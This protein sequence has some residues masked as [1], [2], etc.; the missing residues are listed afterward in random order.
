[1]RMMDTMTKS[2][3]RRP[4]TSI[5][6]GSGDRE[7]DNVVSF[8]VKRAERALAGD[9]LYGAAQS[10]PFRGSNHRPRHCRRLG[11]YLGRDSCDGRT[12][13]S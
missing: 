10:A 11:G 13:C 7:H 3:R 1:M 8:R 2:R 4:M 5:T 9:A 6:A 12:T